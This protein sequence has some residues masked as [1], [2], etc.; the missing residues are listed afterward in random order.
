MALAP[1][2]LLSR[3]MLLALSLC[4]FPVAMVHAASL[5][6]AFRDFSRCDDS[7]FSTGNVTALNPD[8]TFPTGSDG[9]HTWL[10]VGDGML[11][12]EDMQFFST[13]PSLAGL[14]LMRYTVG[15]AERQ[16]HGMT[17]H[18][19]LV[20]RSGLSEA[21][22][23]LWPLVAHSERLSRQ[24]NRYVRAEIKVGE[25]DW[26]ESKPDE[27]PPPDGVLRVFSIADE[28]G[29]GTVEANCALIGNVTPAL[30]AQ[31]RPDQTSLEQAARAV[32]AWFDSAPLPPAMLN[33]I[34]EVQHQHPEW[35]PAFRHLRYRWQIDSF[36]TL[37]H[38][39][40]M[41]FEQGVTDLR[42]NGNLVETTETK[43]PN[44]DV[45]RRTEFAGLI[46]LKAIDVYKGRGG[47]LHQ[48]SRLAL[49]WPATLNKGAILA[50]TTDEAED[51][52]SL[53][54]HRCTVQGEEAAKMLHPA[55]PGR[56]ILL[57]CTSLS[58]DGAASEQDD[59]D[60]SI[61]AFLPNLGVVL[62]VRFNLPGQKPAFFHYRDLLLEK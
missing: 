29:V 37:R 12:R 49:A 46:Q 9:K 38:L 21:V 40:P 39:A 55:L 11:N 62:P 51:N 45:A 59:G 57:R 8:G 41:Q 31:N 56:A 25:A 61:E 33:Q 13:M 52:V 7:F 27:L 15:N 50:F 53:L 34:S 47:D 22:L 60:G 42:V 1:H 14:P 3:L 48:T 43:R 20:V 2:A 19:G 4:L 17:Y 32:P 54:T 5:E 24:G 18:W 58:G 6:E 28:D 36:P 23:R 10:R 35:K 30:L 44:D 26:R 16:P